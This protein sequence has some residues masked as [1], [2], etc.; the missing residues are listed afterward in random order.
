[1]KGNTKK[2]V[3]RLITI[4]LYSAETQEI[5]M[6]QMRLL[7]K[8]SSKTSRKFVIYRGNNLFFILVFK[9][10]FDSETPTKLHFLLNINF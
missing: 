6:K 10:L 1:M 3:A 9:V 5:E 7:S 4:D 2:P 8:L